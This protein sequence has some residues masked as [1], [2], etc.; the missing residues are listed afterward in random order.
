MSDS[1]VRRARLMAASA[2]LIMAIASG[3]ASAPPFVGDLVPASNGQIAVVRVTGH[4]EDTGIVIDGDVRRPNGYAGV[5][6]GYLRIEGRDASGSVIGVTKANWGEFKSRRFRLAYFH[7][8][9]PVGNPA[10]V[11]SITI[12]PVTAPGK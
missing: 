4:I 3:C 6:P 7:A 1:P 10:L 5:V 12:E 2:P 11:K 8:N 9:L